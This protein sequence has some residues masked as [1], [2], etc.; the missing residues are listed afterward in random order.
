MIRRPPRS[1]L[2]PYTT[3]FRSNIVGNNLLSNGNIRLGAVPPSSETMTITSS[4][5]VRVHLSTRPTLV[6][7]ASFSLQ[8]NEDVFHAPPSHFNAPNFIITP[9]V[10]STLPPS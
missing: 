10:T 3:L 9:T 4:E 1:T 7:P 6:P 5:T 8:L 2:F